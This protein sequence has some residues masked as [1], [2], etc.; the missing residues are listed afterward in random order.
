MDTV[1]IVKTPGII[2]TVTTPEG[3]IVT[4]VAGG[5]RGLTGPAGLPVD[6][7][8]AAPASPTEGYTYYNT[9]DHK[10]WYWNGTAWVDVTAS[11]DASTLQGQNG[12]YYLSRDNHTGPS[13]SKTTPVNADNVVLLDS[14]ASG[15]AKNL[16][17]ANIKATLKTYF[18]TVYEA[19]HIGPSVPVVSS[20]T[21]DSTTQLT[22]NWA[23][24]T[25]DVAVEGYKVR[26][27]R[28]ADTLWGLWLDVGKVLT[29]AFTGLTVGTEYQA[30]VR[31]Y[32]IVPN[33]SLPQTATQTTN[34]GF[35]PSDI[36][37]LKLWLKADAITGLADGASVAT[38]ADSSGNGNDATQST[39]GSQPL[40][41]TG[42][43]NGLPVVRFDGA[44]DWMSTP[45]IAAITDWTVFVVAK[46][47]LTTNAFFLSAGG[48]TNSLI[49]DFTAGKWEYFDTPRTV[50]GNTSTTLFQVITSAVG[51]SVVGAWYIGRPSS[52]LVV[53]WGG[54][55][56]EIVA[57]NSLLSAGQITQVQGYLAA[58]YGL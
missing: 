53:L 22:L 8:A 41:K 6:I 40:Y 55:I 49:T 37:G 32:D 36:A 48:D 50:I 15:V 11:A 26:I 18:D 28:T 1:T 39:A 44:D 9:T 13:G 16:T 12:A 21:S 7:L 58:K 10:L 5:Q 17:W 14:A 38:W 24:S 33:E 20:F 30:Q 23:A 29:H 56:A 25:D 35:L 27:K 31:A 42:S 51:G 57:Y 47:A 43:V 2:T 54:D 3:E 52:G 46:N 34:V 45:S 4:T 19:K